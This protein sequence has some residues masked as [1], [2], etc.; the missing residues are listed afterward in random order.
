MATAQIPPFAAAVARLERKT[1]VA[2][3]L[4]TAEWD[5]VALG[6]R[7]R[8]FFMARVNEA[9]T[10]ATAQDAIRQALALEGETFM[11]RSKFIATMRKALGAAPGDSGELTDITSA[12]RLAMVYDMNVQEAREHGRWQAEQSPE[13]LDAY[14][15]TELL[16]V[17]SREEEREWGMRWADAGGLVYGPTDRMIALK[18]DPIWRAI[19]RFGRPYPP[20]DFGSGM[21]TEDVSRT[22]AE[23]LGVLPKDAPAPAPSRE[24]FNATLEATIPK[25][26]PEVLAELRRL[27]GDQVDVGADGKVTWRGKR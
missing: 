11:D 27:F 16:R 24:S 25:A 15:A 18:G 1:P 4:K 12:R 23:T 10:V 3:R 20:F 13:I 17:E 21:G 2:S 26:T 5:E 19:S 9:R 7:D 14:P 6:L 8:A 22:D